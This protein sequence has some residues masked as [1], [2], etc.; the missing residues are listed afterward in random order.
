M[1]HNDLDA[2]PILDDIRKL[3]RSLLEELKPM[4]LPQVA[5]PYGDLAC[6]RAYAPACVHACVRACLRACVLA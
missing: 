5:P 6:A 1:Q 4:P 2:A 3:D